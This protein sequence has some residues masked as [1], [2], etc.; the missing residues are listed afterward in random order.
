[1]IIPAGH[2][3]KAATIGWMAPVIAGFYLI[4]QKKYGWGIILTMVYTCL[5]LM[6]HPQMS[7]YICMLIGVLFIA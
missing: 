4:F 3:T 7:Y 6:L 5:G 1:M 2:N